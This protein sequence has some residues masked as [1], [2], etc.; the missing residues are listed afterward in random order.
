M[1][2]RVIYSDGKFDMIRPQLL[3]KLLNEK[4]VTSF[5]RSGGWATIGRDH[6]RK[7]RQ[8]HNYEGMERRAS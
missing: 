1:L 8:I 4:K 6:I 2:I 5:M 7:N 3:D